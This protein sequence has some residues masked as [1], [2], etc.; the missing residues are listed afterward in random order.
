MLRN[1]DDNIITWQELEK[2]KYFRCRAHGKKL[3]VTVIPTDQEIKILRVEKNQD[4]L[5]HPQ[6][7]LMRSCVRLTWNFR[8]EKK[9]KKHSSF[10]SLS[11]IFNFFFTV[12]RVKAS[13]HNLKRTGGSLEMQGMTNQINLVYQER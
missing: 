1:G 9:R 2:K 11:F 3:L 6:L 4:F 13:L 8:W 12:T 7:I 10:F 5:E